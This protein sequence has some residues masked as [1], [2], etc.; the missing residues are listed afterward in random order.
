M[1]AQ[2]PQIRL[3]SVFP[4]G[5]QVGTDVEVVVTSGVDLDDVSRLLCSDPGVVAVPK[6]SESNGTPSAVA[7]TFTVTISSQASPGLCD[8]R[9][10]GRFGISNPRSF[11]VGT[12]KETQE[13]EP[14]DLFAQATSVELGTVIN[15][16]SNQQADV[17]IYKFQGR[18]GQRVLVACRA[19]AIDSRMLAT[20]EAYDAHGRRLATGHS[21]TGPDP[22]MDLTLPA[23]GDYYL[24]VFDA[25][26]RGGHEYF[27]RLQLHTDAHIDFVIPAAGL[28]GSSETYTLFGRNLPLGTPAGIAA[29]GFPLEKLAVPITLP[30]D[31]SL[32]QSGQHVSSYQADSD[33]VD[34]VLESHDA[35]SNDVPIHFAAN[36]VV[37]E[38]E[39]ND[40]RDAAQRIDV[41]VEI[42]GQFQTLGDIDYFEFAAKAQEVF[43]IDV[44]GQRDGSGADPYVILEQI[45][46][47]KDGHETGA[48]QLVAQD[49]NATDLFPE[50]FSTRSDD[51]TFRT[52]RPRRREVS[53][54]AAR[55][56][57][58]VPGRSPPRLPPGDSQRASRLP[59]RRGTAG[60]F[61][62]PEQQ[63]GLTL[64]GGTAPRGQLRGQG[65]G[66]PPRWL[67][68]A[69]RRRSRRSPPW[70][71]LP[72]SGAGIGANTNLAGLYFH[73]GCGGCVCHHS[74]HRSSEHRCCGGCRDRRFASERG[75]AYSSYRNDRVGRDS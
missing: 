23:D 45:I 75:H 69:D 14:N 66:L 55:Q 47:D 54:F 73:P 60:A 6:L 29:G 35:R 70:C 58:R 43:W 9:V 13:V 20:M 40:S 61:Q 19:V 50:H 18:K 28:A 2:L 17:D 53:Y 38:T 48:T 16:R 11:A 26:F 37:L 34:Y 74:C 32:L 10:A 59:P 25:V 64:A 63:H 65:I 21:A 12:R 51:V 31:D 27:Y 4:T 41:P 68:R 1:R 62:R 72:T 52:D 36:P 8:L 24:K 42:T 49:D 15:A 44:F 39:P 7:N 30:A 5:G 22:L 67:Q 3:H 46:E 57:L 56:V 71:F 33:Q